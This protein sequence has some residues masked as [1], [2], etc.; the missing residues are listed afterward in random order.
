[1]N[2]NMAKANAKAAR[3]NKSKTQSNFYKPKVLFDE[4][5]EPMFR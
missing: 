1:M 4:E 3:K 2:A 5:P